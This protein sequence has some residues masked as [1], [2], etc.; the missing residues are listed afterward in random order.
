MSTAIE[1]F[2]VLP[3]NSTDASCTSR[4]CA[5]LSEYSNGTLPVVSNVEYHF[6]PGE[7]HVP[8]N[9]ELK[10][11]QNFSIVGIISKTS[12]VT[13]V[14]CL[15]SFTI[16]IINSQ[17]VIIKNIIFKHCGIIPDKKIKVTNL[18]MSCC[19]SC[20]IQNVT[21]LQYGFKGFDLIG[22]SYLHNIQIEVTHFSEICCQGI[23][24][25]YIS[26]CLFRESILET[27]IKQLNNVTISH[28]LIHNYT[29]KYNTDDNNVGLFINLDYSSYNVNMLLTNS[30]FYIMDKNALLIINR[31]S[32]TINK[33]IVRN[34][35]FKLITAGT[36][37]HIKLSPND[38]SV[39]FVN[40]NFLFNENYLIVIDVNLPPDY[41]GCKI[42]NINKTFS[43][44]VTKISFI[45]CQF[46][47]N[48]H[49][50]LEITND[51]EVATLANVSFESLNISHNTLGIRRSK[52]YD[53]ILVSKMNVYI[54]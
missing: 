45:R 36:A 46:D 17:F 35:T 16:S 34:C 37:I 53:L 13:L 7:H 31:C 23:F 8:A 3:D 47:S 41:L 19:F 4:P 49:T 14:G 38:Q 40:C 18:Q 21:F 9:M 6:L 29:T 48:K 43:L 44:I 12:P 51:H 28:L 52:I 39:S 1:I 25:Q 24:I 50:L 33:I 5:T 42:L 11:L 10:N 22:E 2:F 26:T 30:Q 20:K 54:N 32:T 27:Y 15:K